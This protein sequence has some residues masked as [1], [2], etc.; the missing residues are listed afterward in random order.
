[1]TEYLL[2]QR[3]T[4]RRDASGHLHF[5]SDAPYD[6]FS[7]N[8][9]SRTGSTLIGTSRV[10]ASSGGRVSTAF[11]YQQGL[12]FVSLGGMQGYQTTDA[13]DVSYDGNAII[14]EGYT[15]PLGWSQP[16][17]SRPFYWTAQTGRIDLPQALPDGSS[18][19]LKALSG[20]GRIAVGVAGGVNGGFPITW[21]PD[22]G[23]SFLPI[24]AVNGGSAI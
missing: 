6:S 21:S 8:A 11:V 3:R 17:I 15:P 19:S 23:Y 16:E 22:T 10:Q 9:V 7:L 2:S 13:V 5:Y 18:T 14:G 12:G 20:D 24:Q 4:Y 1:M